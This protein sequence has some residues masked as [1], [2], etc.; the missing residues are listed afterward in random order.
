MLLEVHFVFNYG[1]MLVVSG[2]V[3]DLGD[4][5][6]RVLLGAGFAQGRGAKGLDS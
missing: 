4:G 6:V 3:S 1:R 5:H 2:L